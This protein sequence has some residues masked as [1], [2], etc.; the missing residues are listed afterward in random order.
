MTTCLKASMDVLTGCRN[1]KRLYNQTTN[2]YSGAGYI[3]PL[4]LYL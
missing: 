2:L 4:F 1:K 3:A